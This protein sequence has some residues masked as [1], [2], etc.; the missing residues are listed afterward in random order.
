MTVDRRFERHLPE[1]LEDLY[2]GP[3]PMISRRGPCRRRPSAAARGVDLPRKVAPD[4]YRDSCRTRHPAA[5]ATARHPCPHRDPRGRGR[6]G[7]G[8]SAAAPPAGPVRSCQERA[9][10]R[11]SRLATS[12][13]VTRRAETRSCSTEA[14]RM[15]VWL[16]L[17]SPPT[18]H[19]WPSCSPLSSIPA[20]EVCPSTSTSCTTTGP[21]C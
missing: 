8:R 7:G 14:P 21:T 5:V 15:K 11:M 16:A 6:S 18:G 17:A 2:L 1:I 12:T 20:P 3:S 9:R 4:G 13:S 19:G 10:S